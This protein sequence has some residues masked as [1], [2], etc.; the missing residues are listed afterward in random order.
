MYNFIRLI[1][2]ILLV[3]IIVRLVNKSKI[4][5]KKK[6]NSV[7]GLLGIALF[8]IL[9]FVP[10][11][12][13]LYFSSASEAFEYRNPEAKIELVIE[14]NE[15]DYVIGKDNGTDVI[16]LVPKNDEHWYV[17]TG[18]E[19]KTLVKTMK[20]NVVITLRQYKNTRDY[21]ITIYEI[22]GE[23]IHL[24]DSIESEFVLLGAIKESENTFTKYYA[25]INDYKEGYWIE[26]NGKRYQLDVS[27]K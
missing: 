10:I 9:G 2:C 25:F 14:G 20:D 19:L 26:V 16:M 27:I 4:S 8:I 24:S 12:N 1:I 15:S 3:A 22:N 23:K 7:C 21:Y 6:V 13:I 11:E 18:T 5:N 17:G